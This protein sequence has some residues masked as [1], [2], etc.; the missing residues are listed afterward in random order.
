[1]QATRL[2][3]VLFMSLVLS[4]TADSSAAQTITHVPL[5]TIYGEGEGDRFGF[6]VSGV[7]DVN[8]D[9]KADLIIGAHQDDNNLRRNSGSVRVIS[10]NDGSVL[11]NVSGLDI[12]GGFGVSVSGCRGCQWRWNARSDRWGSLGRRQQR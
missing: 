10:G 5:Y 1:M 8:G 2:Y 9:G 12:D 6:S 11:F 4:A 7:G 3:T